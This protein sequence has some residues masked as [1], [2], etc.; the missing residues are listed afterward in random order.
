LAQKERFGRAFS[1]K[2]LTYA[3]GRPVEYTDHGVVDDLDQTLKKNDYHIHAL[4][5]AIVASEP[6]TTKS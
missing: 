5:Q 3:L 2:L 6:F 4:I 1:T